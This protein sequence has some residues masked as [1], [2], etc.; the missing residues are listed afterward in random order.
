MKCIAVHLKELGLR[1]T[2]CQLPGGMP[3]KKEIELVAKFLSEMDSGPGT[4]I[5]IDFFGNFTYRFEQSDGV[6]W[7]FQ[8]GWGGNLTCWEMWGNEQNLKE[9]IAKLIPVLS[10]HADSSKVV[11]PAIPRCISGGCCQ[12]PTYASN[13]QNVGHAAAM[14][15]KISHLRKTLGSELVGSPLTN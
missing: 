1:I 12:E 10:T 14:I 6:K 11:L 8:S 4:A 2:E 7:H 5:V 3:N 13:A 15:T 9:L